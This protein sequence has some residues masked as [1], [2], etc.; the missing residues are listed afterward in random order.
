MVSPDVLCS[1]IPSRASDKNSTKGKGLTAMSLTHMNGASVLRVDFGEL[2]GSRYK[3]VFLFRF[4]CFL[5]QKIVPNFES[6]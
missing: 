3:V 5:F 4:S 6:V 2:Q 1:K